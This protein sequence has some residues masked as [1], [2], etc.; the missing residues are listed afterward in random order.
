M[1]FTPVL[2]LVI[3]RIDSFIHLPPE[4]NCQSKQMDRIPSPSFPL[5]PPNIRVN[6]CDFWF[7][8]Q[9]I[10]K[11]VRRGNIHSGKISQMNMLTIDMSIFVTLELITLNG[12]LRS[13]SDPEQPD[14]LFGFAGV[15]E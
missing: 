14:F 2:N 15:F 11:P 1:G 10:E 7:A 9:K 3:G 5:D 12:D 4:I 6:V 13:E 8:K